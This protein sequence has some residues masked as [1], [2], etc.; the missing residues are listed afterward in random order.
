MPDGPSR[1]GGRTGTGS[2]TGGRPGGRSGAGRISGTAPRLY[3]RAYEILAEQI[4]AGQ[5]PAGS[6][7]MESGIA[8]QFGIS[9]A[10]ARQALAELARAGLVEKSRGRGFTVRSQPPAAGARRATAQAPAAPAEDLRLQSA[11][12]WERIYAE[13]EDQIIARI[14]FAAWR[15]NEAELARHYGV[16]RTV[17]RDVVARLQ[18]RGLVRKDERA[19]W[20]AP[21]L[22]PD[23]I[24]ELYELRALLEPPA[25]ERAAG[26][27]PPEL[28]AR[29]RRNLE[30]AIAHAR[31]IDGPVLDAL[32]Q[33]LH[34]ELL[35]R[36]GNRALMQAITL[37]QSLL[38]AHRFLYRWTPR[39][40]DTEPFLPE[41]LEVVDRLQKGR[42]QAAGSALA[43]HLEVSRDRAV[44]RVE[45]VVKRFRPDPLPYLEA[46]PAG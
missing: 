19:R 7:L 40:F 35:A 43:R 24:G 42:A 33:E 31:E 20:F 10:P 44:A 26:R 1:K 18:Q 4:A 21:A 45:D 16:S 13:V 14:S 9:R 29:M 34:V 2:G 32:E 36:C 22:T 23:H 8:A 41:H 46:L 11:A 3:Q 17:A 30:A 12:S 28:L 15:V 5:L 37:P 39:I 38:I 25:L 6:R 27:A